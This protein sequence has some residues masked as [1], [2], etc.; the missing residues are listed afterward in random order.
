MT[1]LRDAQIKEL[2]KNAYDVRTKG[3]SL[4]KVFEDF[5]NKT[6]KAKGSVRNVYYSALKK[7][8]S[9]AEYKDAIL[10]DFQLKATKIISFEDG[11]ADFLL[12]KILIGITFGKSVRRTIG[13]MTDSPKLA[14]RY[15]NK[16]RNIL[17]FEKQRVEKVRQKIIKTYGKCCNPYKEGEKGDAVLDKLKREINGLCDRIA[18]GLKEENDKLKQRVIELVKENEELKQ[19]LTQKDERAIDKYFDK[20]YKKSI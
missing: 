19:I 6:G 14:L 15:Q 18:K 5:A 16:Y 12:E 10:G 9:D 4:S 2:M 13:E 3:G 11:E 7:T 8:E 20:H 17:R 1:K